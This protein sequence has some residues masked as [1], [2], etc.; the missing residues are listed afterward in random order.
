MTLSWQRAPSAR[1]P[2]RIWSWWRLV[3][4]TVVTS[5]VQETLARWI[6]LP[7]A[8][9]ET[10]GAA[11]EVGLQVWR[12]HT[13]KRTKTKIRVSRG[14]R[15]LKQRI[16][17][18]VNTHAI[19][20]ASAIK[21]MSNWCCTWCA[22]EAQADVLRTWISVSMRPD[23]SAWNAKAASFATPRQ[24]RGGWLAQHQKTVLAAVA[25]VVIIL[26]LVSY[27]SDDTS[28]AASYLRGQAPGSPFDVRVDLDKLPNRVRHAVCP[29]TLLRAIIPSHPI[30]SS[31]AASDQVLHHCR[32]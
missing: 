22:Q 16:C 15:W 14:L 25:V 5:N 28:T 19:Y 26:L 6:S 1:T 24:P 21:W 20:T 7:C 32:P 10:N 27:D 13:P 12:E 31:P 11:V 4:G 23:R 17:V 9:R 29:L 30:P 18:F 8:R 2:L 3:N